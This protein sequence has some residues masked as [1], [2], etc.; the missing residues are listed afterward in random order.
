MIVLIC[1]HVSVYVERNSKRE[2]YKVDLAVFVVQN[3]KPIFA[4]MIGNR[5]C[6][7]RMYQEDN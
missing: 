6:H 4:I 5:T 1:L 7:L 3:T 2:N